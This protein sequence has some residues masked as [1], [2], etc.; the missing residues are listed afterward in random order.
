MDILYKTIGFIVFWSYLIGGLV[1][2]TEST[3]RA[4]DNATE[5][6]Y[7]APN[8]NE[9]DT[10]TETKTMPNKVRDQGIIKGSLKDIPENLT[11]RTRASYNWDE[12][13][14]GDHQEFPVGKEG[15]KARAS[16]LAFAKGTKDRAPR[17]FATQ[18]VEKNG[19]KVLQVWRLA[20]PETTEVT[21]ENT[22]ET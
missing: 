6:V 20:D 8:A 12:F 11:N 9:A 7:I 5:L 4:L 17:H 10:T 13:A 2:C 18:T 15:D 1:S 22:S 21:S 19:A 16:A 3:H 14:V